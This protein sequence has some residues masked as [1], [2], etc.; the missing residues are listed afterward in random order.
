[1]RL[2]LVQH[3]EAVT[4]AVDPD[5]PLSEQGRADVERL[6]IWMG[7]QGVEVDHQARGDPCGTTGLFRFLA[8]DR[9]RNRNR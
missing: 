1:M 4:K 3:G 7:A 9:G 2:Y 8:A 6:A 5:R